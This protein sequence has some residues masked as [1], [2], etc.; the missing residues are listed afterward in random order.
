MSELLDPILIGNLLY[1]KGRRLA[2]FYVR[3]YNRPGVLADIAS[4]FKRHRINLW[5]IVFGARVGMGEVGTGFIVADFTEAYVEPEHI[6][7]EIEQLDSV[8]YV[9]LVRPQFPQILA[10]T[11][12]FPIVDD[13]G[14]RYIMVSEEAQKAIV[15]RI[16]EKFGPSGNAFLYYQGM[17]VGEAFKDHCISLGVSDLKKALELLLIY[18]LTTGRYKGEILEFSYGDPLREDRIVLRIHHNWECVVAKRHGFR[19]PASFYER[20]VVAGLIQ[21][22]T[23]KS[24]SVDE[25]KCICRGDPYCEFH[26]TF[27]E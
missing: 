3:V 2:G 10:D 21:A 5:N 6:R 11:R 7:R 8:D 15:L 14:A 4:I 9:E 1:L 12:H 19:E 17:A 25:K 16:K 18:T 23:N 26:V 13:A 22:F 24:V 20:G 27:R